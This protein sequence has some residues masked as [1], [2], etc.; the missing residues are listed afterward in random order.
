MR[1]C[2]IALAAA[3]VAALLT[4][5]VTVEPAA[6]QRWHG[7]GPSASSARSFS[8]GARSFSTGRAFSGPRSYSRSYRAGPSVRSYAFAGPGP[9]VYSRKHHYGHR[10][11]HRH[12]GRLIYGVPLAV[13]GYYE[14][15]DS[16]YYLR[17]RA[18][19]TGSSYWWN[20]YYD[21]INGYDAY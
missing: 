18:L 21:C 9:R 16:C 3:S 1:K 11:A 2:L 14:Y 17:R 13:Y 7:G 8:G 4:A 15:A 6:A 19:E 10:H 12:R 20:R 5:S